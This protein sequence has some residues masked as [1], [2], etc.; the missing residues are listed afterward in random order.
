MRLAIV[1]ATGLVGT[2]MLRVLE[3]RNL[4]LTEV[5]CFASTRS[6]GRTVLFQGRE[7]TARAVAPEAF[8]GIDYVLIAAG[9]D[10]SRQVTPLAIAAGAVVIDNSSAFRM[11]DDVPLVVPEVNPNDALHHQGLIANPNCSTIQLV[12]AVHPLAQAFGLRRLMVSTY[13]SITGAGQKGIDQ[14]EAEAAGTKPERR[15]SPHRLHQNTV[16][17]SFPPNSVDT[18]EEQ[19]MLNETR[20]IM[21]APNLRMA[22][23]C[24]RV[25]IIGGHAESV[26]MEFDQPVTPQQAREI[27]EAAPGVIV[28]DDPAHENYPMPYT[29]RNQDGVFV[30]RIRK[31]PSCEHG[32]LMWV[33]ADNLR[34]GAATN[35]IQ[36]LEL[37]VHNSMH[38]RHTS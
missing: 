32:V 14:L 12:V 29:V 8:A 27:L 6:V 37:L 22:T 16:F 25:P 28:V 18:E 36:I 5:T 26:A 15:I 34:K 35:A 7:L 11:Q 9:S 31:D 38:D 10:I 21:H 2:T 3:E 23:T 13:Q 20:K 4:P 24:V 19:K 1:G 17:H 30:G 33:V